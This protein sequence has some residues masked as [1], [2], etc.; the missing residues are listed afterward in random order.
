MGPGFESQR[1]HKIKLNRKIGLFLCP[2]GSNEARDG[3]ELYRCGPSMGNVRRR[4]SKRDHKIKL[5]RKISAMTLFRFTEKGLL[6]NKNANRDSWLKL[7]CVQHIVW[8]TD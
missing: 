5:N 8:L 7:N 3:F 4:K 1:D 6:T 2:L